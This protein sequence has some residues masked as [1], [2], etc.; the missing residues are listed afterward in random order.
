[1]EENKKNDV[2]VENFQKYMQQ[3]MKDL[4]VDGD[5]MLVCTEK[6]KLF[7]FPFSMDGSNLEWYKTLGLLKEATLSME[8]LYK[9][10]TKNALDKE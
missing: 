5:G 3:P 6:G 9:E 4:G 2:S 7:V 1:M 10:V 8:T